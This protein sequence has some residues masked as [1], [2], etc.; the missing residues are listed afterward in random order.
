M[1]AARQEWSMEAA[2]P[3]PHGCQSLPLATAL[4][5]TFVAVRWP[6]LGRGAVLVVLCHV[7]RAVLLVAG[8][9]PRT[10]SGVAH[11]QPLLAASRVEHAWLPNP[12]VERTPHGGARVVVL[13]SVVPP[14]VAAHVKQ[15]LPHLSSGH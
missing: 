12:S 6:A 10:F 4:C 7:K 11:P 14:S 2:S 8:L 3:A 13:P 9:H 15:G 1:N 5:A